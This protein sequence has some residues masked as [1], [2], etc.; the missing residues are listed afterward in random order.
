MTTKNKT[1]K[2]LLRYLPRRLTKKDRKLESKMLLKSRRLY[3]KGVYYTRKQV[4]SFKSKP[5]KHNLNPFKHEFKNH[6]K[7]QKNH[8]QTGL[9]A[10]L[11]QFKKY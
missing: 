10:F 4:K 9:K 11:K 1:R 7:N 3:K 5:S 6:P 8:G 2:F